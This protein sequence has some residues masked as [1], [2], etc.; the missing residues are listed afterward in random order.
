MQ[1]HTVALLNIANYLRQK[2]LEDKFVSGTFKVTVNEGKYKYYTI[3][4]AKTSSGYRGKVRD[5]WSCSQYLTISGNEVEI[6]NHQ[7]SLEST[8]IREKMYFSSGSVSG[9][10]EKSNR[11]QN[12]GAFS[13]NSRDG[14]T[15]LRIDRTPKGKTFDSTIDGIKDLVLK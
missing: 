9:R 7:H 14:G 4:L 1:A 3:D 10:I 6:S 8:Q 2:D 11:K 12:D 5:W 13:G 15:A